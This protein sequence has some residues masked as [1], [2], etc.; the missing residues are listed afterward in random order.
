MSK[1]IK[2]ID[3]ALENCEVITIPK[4]H[5]GLFTIDKIKRKIDRI[6]CNSI[7]DYL[8]AKEFSIQI[9]KDADVEENLDENFRGFSKS[10]FKRLSEHNDITHIY[11]NYEDGST[12]EFGI[13]WY[14]DSDY[15][16][17]GQSSAYGKDGHFYILCKKNADINKYFDGYINDDNSWHWI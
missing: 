7:D 12:E 5:I 15:Y 9:H 4:Q 2:Y 10:P 1:E 16:N 17:D 13:M 14:G 3:I 6:A 8:I 11:I